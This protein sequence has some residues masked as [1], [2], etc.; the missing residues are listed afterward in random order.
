MCTASVY[1]GTVALLVQALRTADAHG[2]V[3]HVLDDLATTG[4]V[5]PASSGR[6]VARGTAKAWRYVAEMH[7]I[8]AAQAEVGLSDALF[9]AFATVYAELATHATG[10]APGEVPTNVTLEQALE[11]LRI[12]AEA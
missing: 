1:K 4:H 5:D 11:E 12:S 9:E 3:G 6:T 10:V 2:V 8:A 7:E